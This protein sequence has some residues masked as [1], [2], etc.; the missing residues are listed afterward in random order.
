MLISPSGM[1]G[2]GFGWNFAQTWAAEAGMQGAGQAGQMGV[3]K[4]R[5]ASDQAVRIFDSIG[6]NQGKSGERHRSK[7]E[8][9]I[10]QI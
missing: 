10:Q 5:Q 7:S 6:E 2:Q 1:P 3:Y 8:A 9:K 4:G